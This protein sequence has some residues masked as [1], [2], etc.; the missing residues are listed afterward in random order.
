MANYLF[1]LFKKIDVKKLDDQSIGGLRKHIVI[2]FNKIYGKCPK[3][4]E[5]FVGK[6]NKEN[7]S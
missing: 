6:K 5:S 1:K 4:Y 2:V 3:L 7:D